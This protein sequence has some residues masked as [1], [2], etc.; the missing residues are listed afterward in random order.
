VWRAWGSG[1]SR[2]DGR[3]NGSGGDGPAYAIVTDP[4]SAG[5]RRIRFYRVKSF[6][7][8]LAVAVGAILLAGCNGDGQAATLVATDTPTPTAALAPLTVSP[9]AQPMPTPTLPQATPTPR[10]TLVPTPVPTPTAVP[11]PTPIP[12]PTPTPTPT[13]SPTP[14]P[15]ATPQ[16]TPTPTPVPVSSLVRNLSWY[17]LDLT[18]DEQDAAD[19]LNELV[20]ITGLY[21]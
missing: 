20:S 10:P 21:R 7:N 6:L 16:P 19:A 15:T 11:T 5:T 13:P 4:A 17:D 1:H 12:T 18:Q 2:Q 8:V 3:S 9:T 14:A